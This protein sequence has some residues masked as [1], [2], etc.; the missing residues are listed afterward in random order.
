MPTRRAWTRTSGSSWRGEP[1]RVR[2]EIEMKA[3]FAP[4]VALMLRLPNEQK[5]PL[6]TLLFLWPLALLYFA[7]GDG[8]S[9]ALRAWVAGGAAL[10]I[11][12]MAAFYIQANVGWT[13][14]I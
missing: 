8:A 1:G 7:A 4:A 5:L 14:V 13:R 11:Y 6:I 2:G 10:A 3:F 9:T 12:A